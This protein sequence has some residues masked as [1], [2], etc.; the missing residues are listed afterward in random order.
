MIA[1]LLKIPFL[2][3][4]LGKNSMPR[5]E[6]LGHYGRGAIK[7]QG[8]AS[9]RLDLLLYMGIQILHSRGQIW[10]SV[11]K[12]I[13][14]SHLEKVEALKIIYRKIND[15]DVRE[16]I[17]VENSVTRN[18]SSMILE[19]IRRRVMTKDDKYNGDYVPE[20]RTYTGQEMKMKKGAAVL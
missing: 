16:E 19:V 6:I 11:G 14:P 15:N 12:R 9:D 4:E 2:D 18:W 17:I 10:C 3:E 1:S 7:K 13:S 20:Y 5:K 8:S